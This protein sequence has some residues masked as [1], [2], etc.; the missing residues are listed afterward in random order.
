MAARATRSAS[1]KA[2]LTEAVATGPLGALSHDELGVIFDGLA[3]PLQPVVA[4]ALSSTCLG[5]RTPLRAALEVLQQRRETAKALCRKLWTFGA[6]GDDDGATWGDVP[7]RSCT[8]LIEAHELS[9]E[10]LT[11]DNMVTLSMILQTNGLKSLQ[12]LDISESS[13]A[14][15]QAFFE[16]LGRGA[17]P[18]LCYLHLVANKIG[19]AG[20]EALA[21][22][23]RRGAMPKLEQLSLAKNP[24]GNEGLAALVSL[25]KLPALKRLRLDKCDIGDEGVAS[26]VA[27]LGK[28]D[29]KALEKLSLDRQRVR[30]ARRCS[31]RGRPAKGHLAHERF[32]APQ[33]LISRARSDLGERKRRG[34][35]RSQGSA[36][37]A[38]PLWLSVIARCYNSFDL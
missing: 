10:G 17:T 32:G 6:C 8:E 16:G 35:R 9:G 5:L 28:D 13:G 36:R 22:A 2:R 37:R 4:V 21:K 3:D 7:M 1:R 25:R 27:G 12:G 34:V 14:G 33:L 24:I 15:V 23:F 29:F 20:A 30:H 38:P 31:Q 26:L 19:P 18:S 11:I